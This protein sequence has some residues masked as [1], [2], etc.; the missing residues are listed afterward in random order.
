[1]TSVLYNIKITTYNGRLSTSSRTISCKIVT[2]IHECQNNINHH[3]MQNQP[4][5]IALV[6]H[7][8]SWIALYFFQS[9]FQLH[10]GHE[11]LPMHF[12][13]KAVTSLY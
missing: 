12:V 5:Q 6:Q 8:L 13:P 1:M 10:P 4:E 2:I 3:N 7:D 9:S 11:E